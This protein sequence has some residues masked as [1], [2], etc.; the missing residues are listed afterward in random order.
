MVD[1]EKQQKGLLWSAA[2]ALGVLSL[3][4][5]SKS[6]FSY[7]G[8]ADEIYAKS[9]G[10]EFMNA[11]KADRRSLFKSDLLRSFVFIAAAAAVL[12]FY[13]KNKLA[14][15]TAVLAVRFFGGGRFVFYRQKLCKWR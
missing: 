6:F 8:G 3:L 10:P 15:Q 7:T 12:W 9:Y 11:L 4:F 2:A 14:S 13:L 1:K 5:I